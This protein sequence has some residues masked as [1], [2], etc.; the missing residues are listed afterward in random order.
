MRRVLITGFGPFPGMRHNPSGIIALRLARLRRPALSNTLRT[1]HIFATSYAAVDRDLP[2]LIRQHRPD[3]LLM[4]G[5]A[6]RTRH[7]RIETRARNRRSVLIPDAARAAGAERVI[8]LGGPPD[9]AM[10]MPR[11]RLMAAARECRVPARL[12]RDAGTY[13]CN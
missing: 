8:A 4:F 6:G 11:M 3:I 1:A 2:D 7:L 10:P 9:L 13:L 12:S 5:V